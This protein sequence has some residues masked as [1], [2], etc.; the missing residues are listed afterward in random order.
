MRKIDWNSVTETKA[1]SHPVP[2][3]YIVKIAGVEDIEEK[4]YLNISWDYIDGD[5][6]GYNI[7]TYDRWGWWPCQIRRSYKPT[8][9]GFFKAFKTAVEK[10]NP[11]FVFREDDLDAMCG[12]KIGVVLGEEEYVS[13]SGETKT[14]LYVYSVVPVDDVKAGR[15][16][17]PPIKRIA[18]ATEQK[19]YIPVQLEEINDDEPMPF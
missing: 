7:Y 15:A 10:S 17:V 11:G 14:R 9:L 4:E 8:A 18:K 2:G 12:K 16:K 1:F 3:A 13:S 6:V 19:I 5:L